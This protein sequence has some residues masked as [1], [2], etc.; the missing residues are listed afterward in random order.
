MVSVFPVVGTRAAT[1]FMRYGR[2]LAGPGV[3]HGKWE[4][5]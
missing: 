1:E 2:A 5:E 4:R 3:R